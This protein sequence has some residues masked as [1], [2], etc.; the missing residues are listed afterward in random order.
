MDVQPA[1][2]SEARRRYVWCEN[3][4]SAVKKKPEMARADDPAVIVIHVKVA[5]QISADSCRQ[6]L[7]LYSSG[8]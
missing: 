3:Q 8:R 2:H 4:A 1:R 6:P 7:Q 5:M